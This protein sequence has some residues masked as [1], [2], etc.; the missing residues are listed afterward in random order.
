MI[1][2]VSKKKVGIS[3]WV[4]FTITYFRCYGVCIYV[5]IIL[6]LYNNIY[7]LFIDNNIFITFIPQ[8]NQDGIIIVII[9]CFYD[10]KISIPIDTYV[11]LNIN[12]VKI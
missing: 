5:H 3:C 7:H 12:W 8:I 9:I 1:E 11:N 6:H 4:L 10:V 2:R